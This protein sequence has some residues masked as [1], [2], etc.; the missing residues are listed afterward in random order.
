M[1]LVTVSV[2]HR[3]SDDAF[4][5]LF[6]LITSTSSLTV[7]G[8]RMGSFTITVWQT[9]FTFTHQISQ[10]SHTP[11]AVFLLKS[12]EIEYFKAVHHQQINRRQ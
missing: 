11:V 9:E 4:G 12:N 7:I 10:I 8:F 2:S 3:S 5:Y 1:R 6:S